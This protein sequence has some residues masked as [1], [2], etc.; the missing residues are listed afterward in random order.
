MDMR[1]KTKLLNQLP[2]IEVARLLGLSFARKGSISCPFPD[3]EDSNPSFSIFSDGNRWK[4]YGCNRNGGAIDLVKEYLGLS[5]M[6]AKNWLDAASGLTTGSPALRSQREPK[7]VPA[8][9]VS[10]EPGLIHPDPI[11]LQDLYALLEISNS[12]RQYMSSRGFSD[13]T[14]KL[15]GVVEFR[16]P[17]NAMNMLIKKH[18]FERLKVSGLLSK[19]STPCYARFTFPIGSALFPFFQN[20]QIVNYQARVID[21]K[22][23]HAKWRNLN[24]V[25]KSK[26]NY[27]ALTDSGNRSIGIC[28]GVIDTL[29]AIQLGLPSIG[30]LGVSVQFTDVE[31][32]LFQGRV[33]YLLTDWD[34][35]GEKKA[36]E[37]ASLFKSKGV[38]SIRK[39]SPSETA[40]DLNDYLIE[41]S[42]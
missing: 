26:Y 29:S 37:L 4:C 19:K 14:I 31:Y 22:E 42:R 40:N 1:E 32:S 13:K 10:R 30:I 41:I 25:P 33:V 20:G 39:K 27:N 5:F 35:A 38:M 28:E 11:I 8:Y 15:S 2:I 7:T 3:H 36:T 6:E 17:A 12:V 23:N 34:S 24:S 21:E 18:G 9:Q 16:P